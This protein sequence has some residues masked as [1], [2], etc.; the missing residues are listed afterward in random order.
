MPGLW[1]RSVPFRYNIRPVSGRSIAPYLFAE[2]GAAE[3]G[4]SPRAFGESLVS[5]F[6]LEY[7]VIIV[8][9]N[10]R[11]EIFVFAE[12]FAVRWFIPFRL[13]SLF[14]LGVRKR[15]RFGRKSEEVRRDVLLTPDFPTILKVGTTDVPCGAV[16]CPSPHE[17]P[18]EARLSNHPPKRIATGSS[19]SKA[20]GAEIG[21]AG[22]APFGSLCGCPRQVRLHER[23]AAASQK[24]DRPT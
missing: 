21:N 10:K 3:K 14:R 8:F 23:P 24:P 18:I 22:P 1:R 7:T 2:L 5:R 19:G 16:E 12:T 11:G 4:G 6:H 17:Y 15:C 13:N 9:L 20:Y